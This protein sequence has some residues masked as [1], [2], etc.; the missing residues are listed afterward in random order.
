MDLPT[1]SRSRAGGRRDEG[2]ALVEFAL[3]GPLLIAMS[4]GFGSAALHLE[5]MSDAQRAARTVARMQ[6]R[7]VDLSAPSNQDLVLSSLGSTGWLIKVTTL[8]ADQGSLDIEAEFEFGDSAVRT[9]SDAGLPSNLPTVGAAPMTVAEVYH[10]P[11]Y[12]LP[13]MFRWGIV[14]GRAAAAR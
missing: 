6:T 1:T 2:H 10:R 8:S 9:G 5:G 3:V 14:Y 13:E 7:G 12:G 11:D 4:I